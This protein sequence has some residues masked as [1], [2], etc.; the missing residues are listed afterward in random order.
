MS[1]LNELKEAVYRCHHCRACNLTDSDEIGWHRVCPTYEAY[2]FEHYAAGGRNA[3]VRAWIEG[4]VEQPE[5]IVEAI[6]S[7][8][9]CGACREI[10]QAYTDVPFPMPDGV[11]TPRIMRAIRSELAAKGFAPAPIEKLDREVDKT[12]NA[13]G[14]DQAVRRKFSEELSLPFKGETLFFAGCSSLFKDNKHT[15][16]AVIKILASTESGV[17]FLGEKEW[18]CGI[19]QYANGNMDLCKE[20]VTHNIEAIRESGAKQ[21]VTNCA[22]CYHALAAIYPNIA[23][24]ELPFRVLHTTQY[25]SELLNEKKITFKKEVQATVTYHDPCHLGRGSNVYDEPR[26]VLKHIPGLT[27]HEM[28][29]SREQAW[30]CGGGEGIVS[31]AYPKLASKIAKERIRQARETG[32]AAIVTSCPHCITMLKTASGSSGEQASMAIKDIIELVTEALS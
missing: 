8:L 24:G 18:C 2:P 11:D 9:G 5:G 17:A 14:G 7:C 22:G 15:A 20:M 31:L 13:F 19:L 1:T 25:L 29:K 28:E 16:E 32:A 4:L 26:N 21:V 10:C 27:L 23:G 3:I 12:K 30:C 6:Y